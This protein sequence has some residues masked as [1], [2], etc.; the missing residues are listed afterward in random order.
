MKGSGLLRWMRRRNASWPSAS[1]AA[2]LFLASLAEAVSAD[3]PAAARK[4]FIE[5]GWD[6]P[7]TALLRESWREMELVTP[8]T[9]GF[10][11]SSAGGG[12][13]R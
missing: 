8:F 2:V 6:I 13:S 9:S 11:A 10:T 12:V 7:S 1:V 3:R 4:K 5:L